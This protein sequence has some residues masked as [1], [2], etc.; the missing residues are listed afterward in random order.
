[1]PHDH[2]LRRF[3]LQCGAAV[4]DLRIRYEVHGELNAAR[5]NAVLFPTWFGG[6]HAAN[7]WIIGPGRSL[8][9]RRHCVIVV[10]ALGNGESSSPSNHPVLAND[11][12]PL[13]ITI[14]DNVRAQREVL[15]ALGIERLH[16]IV[17]RSM[18]AQHALQWSCMYPEAVGR[19]FAFCGLPRTTQ[20]NKLL[21]QPIID[22]LQ[23]GLANGRHAEALDTAAS[24]YASWTLSHEFFNNGVWKTAAAS[25]AQWCSDNV[26]RNFRQFHPADLLCLA[27]TWQDADVSENTTFRG[28]L[29]A[30]LRAMKAPVLLMS[31]SHDLIFPPQDVEMAERCI[32]NAC[33]RILY[34][35]WGHRAGA[36][37][38]AAEDV[39]TLE[40][41]LRDFITPSLSTTESLALVAGRV[42]LV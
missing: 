40:N 13:R 17:G 20:H 33:S 29:E 9:T 2:L 35:E 8:D 6:R 37:G 42:W 7:A 12:D 3:E 14:L 24:I 26:A 28:D 4:D 41:A 36:P 39:Q 19:T 38:S 18:G 22:V 15:S 30:A 32:P 31:I 23:Q 11:G 21:L 27:R 5:D 10:D 16:A 25:A 1:M 34:S